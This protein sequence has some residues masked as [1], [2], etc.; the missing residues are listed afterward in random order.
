MLIAFLTSCGT[1]LSTIEQPDV[2]SKADVK[3]RLQTLIVETL[4]AQ[5][6]SLSPPAYPTP[7]ST[8]SPTRTATPTAIFPLEGPLLLLD[9]RGSGNWHLHEIETGAIRLLGHKPKFSRYLGWSPD[10]CEIHFQMGRDQVVGVDL[11]GNIVTEYFD[12]TSWDDS[13]EG[14]RD[15]HL[16][17]SP[18][19]DW[20]AYWVGTG[21]AVQGHDLV[22]Y[23]QEHLEIVSSDG[24]FG[25]YR[26]SKRGGARI[27]AVGWS[28][29]ERYV[30][31]PDLDVAGRSQL[32]I[33]GN[34]GGRRTQLTHFGEEGW[35]IFD[36][37]WSADGRAI[38]FAY[39]RWPESPE[40]TI[41]VAFTD[42][43]APFLLTDLISVG[44]Y[45]WHDD[46]TIGSA[47]SPELVKW[48]NI[49]SRTIQ[50][51]LLGSDIPGGYMDLAGPLGNPRKLGFFSPSGFYIYDTEADIFEKTAVQEPAPL[52]QWYA[53][54]EDFHGEGDCVP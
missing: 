19:G 33:A 40:T 31:F 46:E 43:G 29:D 32:Y 6:P 9:E 28:P 35:E 54:P 8:V 45:W 18:S 10:G 41:G 52:R 7:T 22:R 38:A 48:V 20:L 4:T 23:D 1:G 49:N 44:Y 39:T 2:T 36:I 30:A 25:P 50:D 37:T 21:E 16:V 47:E 53:S 12:F 14:Q 17:L 24:E 42:G 34:N 13:S 51:R 11:R 27:L 5:S 3:A 26:I 15:A